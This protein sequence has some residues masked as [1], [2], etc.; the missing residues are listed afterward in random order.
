MTAKEFQQWFDHFAAAFPAVQDFVRKSDPT[1]K[2]TL[3]LWFDVLSKRSIADALEVTNRLFEGVVHPIPW[4]DKGGF[5]DWSSV[6]R[7]VARLCAELR[8]VEPEWKQHTRERVKPGI[9]END[10]S[11]RETYREAVRILDEGGALDEMRAYVRSV[12]GGGSPSESH[13]KGNYEPAFDQF[14]NA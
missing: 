9:I 12:Y 5:P 1:G 11:M 7:H 2:A 8:P 13:D 14:N 10:P 4:L 3:T 6:P